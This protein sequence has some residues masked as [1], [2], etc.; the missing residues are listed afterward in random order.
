MN[1]LLCN[2]RSLGRY[3]SVRRVA[4][5][6]GLACMRSEFQGLA[7]VDKWEAIQMMED[8]K[9]AE[10]SKNLRISAGQVITHNGGI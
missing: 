7:F 5:E 6:H 8:E 9:L 3:Q 2:D 4:Y 1:G 10:F